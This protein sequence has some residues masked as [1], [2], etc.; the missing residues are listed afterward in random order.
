MTFRPRFFRLT[1]K[2]RFYNSSSCPRTLLQKKRGGCAARFFVQNFDAVLVVIVTSIA[3]ALSNI[4]KVPQNCPE[5][6]NMHISRYTTCTFARGCCLKSFI[7]IMNSSFFHFATTIFL[8][9]FFFSKFLSKILIKFFDFF[10]FALTVWSF[11]CFLFSLDSMKIFNP[12]FK[13]HL[14]VFKN[15]TSF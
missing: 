5:R 4:H 7:A 11:I 12:I 1:L 10:K 9:Y 14:T 15:Q 13:A 8:F 6:V 2:P 3:D